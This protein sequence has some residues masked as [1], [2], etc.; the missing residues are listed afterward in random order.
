[1]SSPIRIIVLVLLLALAAGCAGYSTGGGGL[2]LPEGKRSL[3]IRSV[4]NPTMRADLEAR[5]RSVMRDEMTRRGRIQWSEPDQASAYVT[6]RVERFTSTTSITDKYD[7]SVL[8]SAQITLSAAVVDS[9]GG[10]T[11]W[12]SGEI[13]ASQNFLTGDQDSAEEKVI[14]LA[15]RRIVDRM[16]QNF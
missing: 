15:V 13:T 3:Y 2:V 11:L 16:H 8:R 4:D 5:L 14:D 12:S 9:A 7:K 1:M 10:D 6:L